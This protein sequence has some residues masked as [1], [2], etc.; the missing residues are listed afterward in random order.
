[1]IGSETENRYAPPNQVRPLCLQGLRIGGR[2]TVSGAFH[3]LCPREHNKWNP[4]EHR[5]F[6]EISRN[7]W[8]RPLESFELI[9]NYIATTSTRTG[10]RV[11]SQ[12][13]AQ[14]YE[15][16]IRITDEQMAALN[17]TANQHIPKWNY[18]ISPFSN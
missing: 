10:L 14:Q 18:T 12:L 16:G 2:I 8:G 11:T 6:S 13:N 9:L 3:L 4:I 15:T 7:W 1:M 5:L 17:I